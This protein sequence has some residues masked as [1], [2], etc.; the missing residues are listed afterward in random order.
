MTKNNFSA[1][2]LMN[3][4]TME[5]QGMLSNEFYFEFVFQICQTD[6]VVRN[7]S[8]CTTT[9]LSCFGNWKKGPTHYRIDSSKI[10]LTFT[11]T[12]KY[13][14]KFNFNID[15][16]QMRQWHASEYIII[17]RFGCLFAKQF[18]IKSIITLLFQNQ[19]N[20]SS[21]ITHFDEEW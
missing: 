7:S 20:W 18:Q 6:S 21:I 19:H 14:Q 15:F 8:V 13:Q 4:S 16:L 5:F 12:R 3:S 1:I 11:K 17:E 9:V 2:F 10:R